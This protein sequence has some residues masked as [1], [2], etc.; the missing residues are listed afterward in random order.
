MDLRGCPL[1]DR[2][3]LA[4]LRALPSLAVLHLSGC[5]KL[6]PAGCTAVLGGDRH[7][8]RCG[9]VAGRL[10]PR[11]PLRTITLQRCFQLNAA[12]LADVLAAAAAPG[13]RLACAALS[14]LSLAAWPEACP[15][16]SGPPAPAAAPGDASALPP[17]GQLRMLALHNCAK[18]SSVTLAALAAACPRLEV[19]ML[20][21]CSFAV[22]EGSAASASAGTS[23]GPS[24]SASDG[25]QV[26]CQ[27]QLG[28]HEAQAAEL[29]ETALVAALKV[30]PTGMPT[31]GG[32]YA[33]H[34]AS[35]AAS[36]AA[37]AVRLPQ[38]RVLELTFAP[39]GLVPTL[40]HLAA[41]EVS[42]AS[43]WR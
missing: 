29:H 2:D 23:G 4:A 26:A 14:H 19:L 12:A 10:P 35:L 3:I 41:T 27:P 8:G 31:M 25:Y 17:A 32:G 15:A 34:V 22:G 1:E 33:T 40:Q 11:R 5:K 36:L 28:A 13:S 7:G 30:M 39:P 37:S 20:G 6:T 18:L 21:G 38:L 42:C 9:A 24:H 16:S 43:C